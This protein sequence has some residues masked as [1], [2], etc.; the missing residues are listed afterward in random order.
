MLFC[1][2]DF[3][4]ISRSFLRKRLSWGLL[5]ID[6]HLNPALR[7]GN[8]FVQKLLFYLIEIDIILII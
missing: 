1:R 8:Q 6:P 3:D 7:N 5:A 4:V 2:P